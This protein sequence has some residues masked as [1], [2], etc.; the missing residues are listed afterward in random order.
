MR[1]LV[2][3]C[4]G[5]TVAQWLRDQGYEVFSIYEDQRGLSDEAILEKAHREQ[6][7]IVTNDKDFGEKVF[8]EQHPH[9]GIVIL[10]LDDER[11][12]NKINVLKRLLSSHEEHLEDRF[13]VV[14]EKLIRFAQQ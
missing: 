3:E 11:A 1:F 4:T 9:H 12:H 6:W 2:D 10:R 14:T 8:R 7:V 5:P 13:V